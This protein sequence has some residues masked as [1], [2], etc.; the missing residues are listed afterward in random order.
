MTPLKIL[1][2]EDNLLDIE[3]I[4]EELK[5]HK[6]KY[7]YKNV[8]TKQK[9]VEALH[10]FKPDIILSDYN[11]PQFTGYEALKIV[12][13]TS[14]N[15]PFILVTGH[16][17]EELA[18]DVIKKG[19]WD[20]VLKTNTLRLIPAIENAL[21]LKNEKEKNEQINNHLKLLNIAI[22]QS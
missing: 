22:E 9:F 18:V 19:A 11:L 14:P 15:C 3:L 2:L 10:S 21:K 12:K 20:F 13:K 16:L 4:K 17:S 8:D 7:I 1:I 6:L 5:S